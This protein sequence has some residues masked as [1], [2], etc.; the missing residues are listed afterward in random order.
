MEKIKRFFLPNDEFTK[1]EWILKY[2]ISALLIISFFFFFGLMFFSF[3]RLKQGNIPVG[4]SQAFF[5]IFLLF[6]FYK[7]KRDKKFYKYY[8]FIFFLFF[9]IYINIV[10]F[11]V[12]ENS[13]N[14]LWIV[15]APVLIF[16]FLDKIGGFIIF[17]LL[18][19]FVSYLIYS[20][21]DYTFAEYF[22]LLAVLCTS[23]FI[24]YYYEKIKESETKNLLEYSKNLEIEVQI[25]TKELQ[26]LNHKLEQRVEEELG[27]RI[28]Q[29]KILLQQCR[30]ASMGEMIDSIAH[31]WRQPLMNINSILMN[32]NRVIEQ[33]D[34]NTEPYISN[35]VDD[36]VFLT[37]HMSQTIEDFRQL[38]KTDK[39]KSL[40]DIR[41]C[42]TQSIN[43]L[44]NSFNDIKLNFHE[45]EIKLFLGHENEF[46]QVLI[47][48]INNAS[49]A[50][51]NNNIE[52]KRIDIFLEE[53]DK[54]IQVSVEDNARGIDLKDINSIFDPYF[55]TKEAIGGSGLGLYIAKIIIEQNMNGFL[56]V[57]NTNNGAR[58][59]IELKENK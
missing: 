14:I 47:I 54:T 57:K 10:F 9:F 58:F 16:F 35:K 19:L 34:K 22:T 15:S 13:L 27:K 11:L 5:C 55:T 7:T 24:L 28:L 59:M 43:I 46:I 39:K 50:L 53:K 31:Q 21:Y 29:E 3:Y 18:M 8:S 37:E 20:S 41:N 23:A 40:F 38:F 17:L 33:K 4:L 30:M 51:I 6:G 12:P 25:K 56:N 1:E 26:K 32:V 2:K 52:N 45:K 36:I 48:L 42:I 49:E 44:K